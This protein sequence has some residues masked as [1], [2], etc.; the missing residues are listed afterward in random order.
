[1]I[2][3]FKYNK[4]SYG[5]LIFM[6]VLMIVTCLLSHY[7]FS[8]T[9]NSSINTQWSGLAFSSDE[10]KAK[11]EKE[12]QKEREQLAASVIDVEK[13][14]VIYS[15]FFV[16]SFVSSIIVLSNCNAA[17]NK[18]FVIAFSIITILASAVGLF[19]SMGI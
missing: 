8:T 17:K 5:F 19:G 16:F 1:M 6:S 12:Q 2:K 14:K 10:E 15:V 18:G 9:I 7:T 11:F 3:R 13:N 4:Q